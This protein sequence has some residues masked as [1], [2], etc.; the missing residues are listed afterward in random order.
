MVKE[1]LTAFVL[2]TG[3]G[4]AAGF[5]FDFYR[6]LRRVLRLRKAGALGGDLL[7]SLFLTV[8]VAGLLLVINY[9][10]M[11]FYVILG[12]AL[13]ALTYWRYFSRP[14]YGAIMFFFRCAQK[15]F[16]LFGQLVNWF[17]RAV[18]FPFRLIFLSFRLPLE[19]LCRFG[20]GIRRPFQKA[21][22]F[23]ANGWKKFLRRS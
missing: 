12:L 6:A 21:A 16:H 22:G 23:V 5:C 8:F 9:G 18:T 4:L 17:W 7:F 14:G 3:A 20:R 15:L 11:R 19:F 10:E 2:I 13:G 1:Q